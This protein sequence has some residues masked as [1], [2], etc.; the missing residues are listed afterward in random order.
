[1]PFLSFVNPIEAV[2]VLID[3]AIDVIPTVYNIAESYI[4]HESNKQTVT[5]VQKG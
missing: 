2:A 4:N 5:P 3:T 1:M